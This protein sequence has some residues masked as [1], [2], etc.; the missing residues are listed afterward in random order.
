[1]DL[2]YY[3]FDISKEVSYNKCREGSVL[4]NRYLMWTL[5][6]FVMNLLLCS[7]LPSK[8]VLFLMLLGAFAL[9]FVLFIRF[10][11]KKLVIS[12]LLAFILSSCYFGW[13]SDRLERVQEDLLGKDVT[14]SG[15]ITQLGRNSAG[16]LLCY[17][18]KL[19]SVQGSQLKAP[20][21]VYI[22]LYCDPEQAYLPGTKVDGRVTFFD[23]EVE[24]GSGREDRILLNSFSDLEELHFA[25][26]GSR[27]FSKWVYEFRSGIIEKISFGKEKTRSLLRSVCFGD[28]EALDPALR[29]SLRRIGLSHVT[30]VSGL[31]LSFTILLF[32]FILMSAG[33]HYRIRYLLDIFI[34]VAFTVIVGFPLSCVR[35]CIMII[36]MCLGMV[37][38]LLEDGLTSLSVAAFLIVLHNPFAIRD[39]GFLLS[40]FATAGIIIAKLPIENFLFPK[41]L[42]KDHRVN[43]AYRKITGTFACSVAATLGTL[44]IIILVF[45]TVSLVG[46]FA[47]VL[48]I[49]PLQGC[50]MAGILMV[51]LGWIPG[52]GVLLG[53]ICDALYVL[54]DLIS[55]LLGRLSFA[56]VS[57]I[58]WHGIVLLVLFLTV[59]GVGLYDYIAKKKRTT[60]LLTSFFLCFCLLFH[61]SYVKT[62]PVEGVEIAFI[63]VGQGDCTVISKGTSAVILDYGGSAQKRYQ[64][65]DYLQERNIYSV[66]LLGFTHL[67]SDHTNGLGTL[68]KNVYVDE[69]IYSDLPADNPALIPMI[70]SQRHTVIETNLQR[71]VLGNVRISAF[72]SFDEEAAVSGNENGICYRISYGNT[73][74][75]VTGDLSGEGELKLADRIGDVTVLKVS[76]HGSDTS[77]IY[78][79]IKKVSPEISVISVGENSFGLPDDSVIERL[80]TISAEVLLTKEDGTVCFKTDGKIIERVNK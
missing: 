23:S 13:T 37:L 14:V 58:D 64:L 69:I 80:K 11:F 49:Y 74:V 34:A 39:V 47:N 17:K 33:L 46:P 42:G 41:K 27:S 38:N 45:R 25:P 31:H 19:D 40:V 75:L 54:I 22:N 36:L 63:D 62:H 24:F 68:L 66:E 70:S 50:F 53:W 52:V 48:L 10:S 76:H 26:S 6:V 59:I 32:N 18:V 5:S 3:F 73:S 79:F 44:P 1:M 56:S 61:W 60:V 35:A 7:L 78:P 8:V 16:N 2:R 30:A 4:F 15:E 12:C 28:K 29:V 20:G 71:T 55:K 57:T 72:C 21:A 65:I 43:W 67:H 9:L 51:L 77:S